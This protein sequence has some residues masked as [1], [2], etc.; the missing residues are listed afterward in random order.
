MGLQRTPPHRSQPLPS[1]SPAPPPSAPAPTPQP[2]PATQ[3]T[4]AVDIPRQVEPDRTT[5]SNISDS[6]A[7]IP[8]HPGVMRTPPPESST[9]A[10]PMSQGRVEHVDERPIRPAPI[11]RPEEPMNVD[12]PQ[13]QSEMVV[14]DDISVEQQMTIEPEHS[15]ENHTSHETMD[16]DVPLQQQQ[17]RS[18]TPPPQ[19]EAGPSTYIPPTT[20]SSQTTRPKT[21]R[22][23][24][25][26]MEPLPSPP[27]ILPIEEDEYQFGRRY[28]LTME[29]LERAVKAGAQR[30]TADHLRGCFPQLTKELGKPMEDVCMAAS[31]SMRN[32]ILASAQSLMEHYKVGPALRAIDEVDKDA[33][34]YRRLNPPES[35]GGKMG[36]PDAWRPDVSPNALTIASVLPVY[37]ESYSKLR[38]EYSE[39]H[40]YCSEKYKTLVEKQNQLSE[41]ENGVSDG[42]I[43]LEKT[44]QILDNLPMEDMMIWTESAETKLE[45][46]APEQIQ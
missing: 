20:P 33:K 25:K 27:R 10:I 7:F 29:T 40:K 5:I 36:R 23:R 42:V 30:W 16:I 32:N 39:L 24:R 17:Q 37:D 1:V 45:T 18:T 41:L 11:P 38:E 4:E 19:A 3:H 14:E 44:I 28:Q 13:L 12:V 2:E 46:R 43:E 21:P 35:E 26:T 8:R 15:P 34:D 31:Q 22:S 9:Q 6:K